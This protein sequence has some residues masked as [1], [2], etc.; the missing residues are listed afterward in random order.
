MKKLKHNR[1][2]CNG[3]A[4]KANPSHADVSQIKRR[5][6]SFDNGKVKWLAEHSTSQTWRQV[7]CDV[8]AERVLAK[9]DP[10]RGAGLT[11]DAA[12]LRGQRGASSCKSP[13]KKVTVEKATRNDQ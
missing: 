12:S 1:A 3:D 10:R 8:L 13:W 7:A 2:I 9:T 5:V 11:K 4:L 6:E